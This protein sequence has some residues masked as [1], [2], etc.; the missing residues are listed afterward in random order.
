MT[1]ESRRKIL[2]SSIVLTICAFLIFLFVYPYLVKAPTCTDNKQNGT[3]T[4]IDCGGSCLKMCTFQVD[5]IS[6][7]WS[8]SFKV[9]DGRYNAVAYLENHNKNAVVNKLHYR[10]RIA[11][12][13]NIYIAS[14]E[15]YTYVPPSGKFAVFEP[16]IG[17]GNSVPV[18]TTFE[19]LEMPVWLAVSQ[20]K[21]E[22]LKVNVDQIFLE[23]ENSFPKLKA[24][25]ENDSLFKIPDVNIIV[26]LYDASGE[27][28]SASKTYLNFL[29][30][31][32]SQDIVFTWPEPFSS[33]IVN[34]EIIPIYNIFYAS[35]N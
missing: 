25:I 32:T 31:K 6:V 15:G 35:L 16:A 9:V 11:D 18:Y 28:I 1:W 29:Y 17:V 14:R 3:E 27:A 19:F 12:K 23:N 8:K 33:K 20:D 21:I 34:K 13:D 5:E 10:F 7:L 26:I 2:Y 24:V 22:Q 30:K 4:G